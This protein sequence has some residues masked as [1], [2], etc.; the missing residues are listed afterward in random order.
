MKKVRMLSYLFDR[1]TET[2]T[3]KEYILP[4]WAEDNKKKVAPLKEVVVIKPINKFVIRTYS[5]N[6]ET[7]QT[8]SIITK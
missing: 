8:I 6:L 5:N 7:F 2:F 3:E 4:R 1:L